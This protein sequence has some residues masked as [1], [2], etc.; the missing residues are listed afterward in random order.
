MVFERKGALCE[1]SRIDCLMA[2]LD[3]IMLV[4]EQGPKLLIEGLLKIEE[5]QKYSKPQN[6]KICSSLGLRQL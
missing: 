5:R 1:A 2:V 4:I 3:A 6:S